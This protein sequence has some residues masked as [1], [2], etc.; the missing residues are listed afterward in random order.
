MRWYIKSKYINEMSKEKM[1]KRIRKVGLSSLMIETIIKH[2]KNNDTLTLY[3][4]NRHF[5]EEVVKDIVS[6]CYEKDIQFDLA[7][8][9]HQFIYKSRRVKEKEPKNKSKWY[10]TFS[11]VELSKGEVLSYYFHFN[12]K[13]NNY[14]LNLIFD[15]KI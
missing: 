2:S 9:D 1:F 5:I 8:D 3:S 14:S 12:K 7:S 6:K 13:N 4:D 10:Y 11:R 15:K